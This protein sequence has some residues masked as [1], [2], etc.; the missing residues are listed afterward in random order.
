M[1]WRTPWLLLLC[2]LSFWS[3]PVSAQGFR[4]AEIE[5][6]RGELLLEM[7]DHPRAIF[8]FNKAWSIVPDLRYLS[9]L[10][11]AYHAKG[12]GEK[13]LV[14]GELYLERAGETPDERVV[15]IVKELRRQLGDS[16]ARVDLQLFPAG[17]KLTVVLADGTKETSAVSESTVTRWLPVG[18]VV[19]LYEKDGFA[20]V[21]QALQ[22]DRSKTV[23]ATLSL[24]D[25]AGE[26]EL[27]I[28]ANVRNAVVYLD[29]KEA[30]RTPFKQRV[31]AGDHIVQVWAENHLAWTGVVDAPAAR[32][33]S[34]QASLVPATQ[35]VAGLPVPRVEVEE[36]SRF[37]RL[38]TWGWV[39]MG[40]GIA[41]GG[42]AGY[43][44]YSFT[45]K[46]AEVQEAPE[47]S[48][49]ETQLF[50]EATF[51]YNMTMVAGIAGGALIG[52]GLLMVLLDKGD[53]MEDAATFE[54]LTLS[55]GI[56]P[57]AVFLDAAFSF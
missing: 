34:V 40:A 48:D 45:Q 8:A 18:D 14:H 9:G 20:P 11:R 21:K 26:A 12:E 23:S 15:D 55:P 46:W 24:S 43:L 5:F 44:Y 6:N 10:T 39:T 4:E 33:V 47:G 13:A 2:V 49:E 7:K 17:G 36:R 32:A 29:G 37:W 41:A 16:R 56:T 19:V 35:K 53:E 31:E 22:V 28:D 54:L 1:N 30:G 57:D 50:S 38:S 25:A 52:G 27:V 51:L 3:T 42:G